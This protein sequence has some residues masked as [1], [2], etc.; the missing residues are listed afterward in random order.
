MTIC[1]KAC[2]HT[3]H[4]EDNEGLAPVKRPMDKSIAIMNQFRY[5][6]IEK[7]NDSYLLLLSLLQ[8]HRHLI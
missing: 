6:T 8:E 5:N 2:T 7:T 4:A 1:Y 3:E